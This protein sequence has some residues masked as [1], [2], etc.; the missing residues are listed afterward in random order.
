MLKSLEQNGVTKYKSWQIENNMR[1]L[2]PIL[3]Q[4]HDILY[5]GRI[6]LL[7]QNGTLLDYN[8]AG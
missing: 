5:L 8:T 3:N 4:H 7:P 2:K 1:A 6:V